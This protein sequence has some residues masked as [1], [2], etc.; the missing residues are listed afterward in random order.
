[1]RKLCIKRALKGDVVHFMN[2][3]YYHAS[4]IENLTE[5]LPFSRLHESRE[6][7]A[8][9]TPFRAY[10]L[11]YLRDMEINH[12]TCGVNLTGI[13]IYHE[14]FPNQLEILYQNRS[15][16]L[17]ICENKNMEL[18]HT[19][20]VWV[21]YCPVIP[22]RVDFIVDVY[23]EILKAEQSGEV[24]II[25]YGSLSSEKKNDYVNMMKEEILKNGYLAS[26]LPKALFFKD[27]FPES[28]KAAE[29]ANDNVDKK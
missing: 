9:F 8:Y 11:F 3:V 10:A 21:A 27:N 5:I 18:G 25:R 23:A 12:V 29:R 2:D 24:Q 4:N 7:V 1:V 13:S 26:N 14:Q 15:G 20:G 6:Q 28:W 19:N 16:Y 22:S 17:Y